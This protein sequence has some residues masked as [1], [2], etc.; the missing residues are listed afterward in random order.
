MWYKVNIM[1]LQQL[2]IS[3]KKSLLFFFRTNSCSLNKSFEWLQNL[4]QSTNIQFDVIAITETRITKNTSVTQNI[5]VSIYSFEH[6]PI[7]SFAGDTR[8][9][10]TNHLSYN[11][12]SDLNVYKKIKLESTFVQMMNPEK[13]NIIIGIIYRYPKLDV[14]EFNNILNNLLKKI[15]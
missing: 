12:R 4:L 14:T 1:T 3:N 8:L 2:K 9:H 15:N 5:E 13:S 10:I 6:N 11:T 7:E